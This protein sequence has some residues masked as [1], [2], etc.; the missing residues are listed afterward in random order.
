M[1]IRGWGGGRHTGA[2]LG[3]AQS[4]PHLLQGVKQR[5]GEAGGDLPAPQSLARGFLAALT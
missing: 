1:L 3:S 5:A 2:S 4:A